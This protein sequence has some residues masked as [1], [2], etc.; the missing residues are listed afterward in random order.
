[1]RLESA[2]ES[3]LEQRV[4]EGVKRV[5]PLQPIV[6]GSC[7]LKL[8]PRVSSKRCDASWQIAAE[9]GSAAAILSQQHG[10]IH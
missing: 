1:M 6:R 3:S 2:G 10:C 5:Q 8:I 4:R 9:D 7:F